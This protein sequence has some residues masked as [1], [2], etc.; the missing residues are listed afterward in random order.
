MEVGPVA[1]ELEQEDISTTLA[2]CQRYCLD[3][4]PTSG[5]TPYITGTGA[6]A[7]T[8]VAVAHV[9]FPVQR[10]ATPSLVFETAGNYRVYNGSTLTVTSIGINGMS[11]VG[12]GVNFSGS[13]GLTAA[14]AVGIF[15]ANGTD[16]TLCVAEL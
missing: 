14:T 15:A 9:A 12:G 3:L 13:S 8:V 6:C 11:P 2:K 10:R 1:T 7:N 4:T 16:R 5:T